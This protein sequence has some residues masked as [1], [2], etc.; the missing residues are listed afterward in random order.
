VLDVLSLRV[1]AMVPLVVDEAERRRRWRRRLLM[2]SAV[3]VAMLSCGYVAW[4]MQ[5]WKYLA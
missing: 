4:S 3:G 1:L 5:L 2:G